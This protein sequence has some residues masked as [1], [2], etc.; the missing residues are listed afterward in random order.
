V[1]KP[2]LETRQALCFAGWFYV[3]NALLLSVAGVQYFSDAPPPADELAAIFRAVIVPGHFLL[4][5]APAGLLVAVLAVTVPGRY[6]RIGAVALFGVLAVLVVADVRVFAL[7]RFHLNSMVW[8]LLTSGVAEEIVPVSPRMLA[9]VA[10]IVVALLLLEVLLARGLWRLLARRRR[11]RG[12]LVAAIVILLVVA[13]QALHAYGDATLR[14]SV[15]REMRYLPWLEGI[16]MKGFL[17][18]LGFPRQEDTRVAASHERTSGLRYPTEP[19]ECTRAADPMNVLI[20][21]IEEWRFDAL[22]PTTTPN[23]WRLAQGGQRFHAHFSAGSSSRYGVFGLMYGLHPSYWDAVLAEHRGTVMIEEAR[24]QGYRFQIRGSASLAHP[25]FDRTVFAALR[26]EVPLRT[27][28]RSAADRDRAITDDFLAFAERKQEPFFGF[29]FYDSPHSADYPADLQVPY[30]PVWKE[31]DYLELDADFD[32]QPYRN[33][34]NNSVFYVDRLIGEVLAA[35]EKAGLDDDTVVI[36]TGDHGEEFNDSGLNYW[37]HNSNFSR[38]QTQVPLVVRWPGRLPHEHHGMT[39]HLDVVPT[40]MGRV[41]GCSTPA[42]AYSNGF[43]L[44]A[45]ARPQFVSVGG[46]SGGTAVIEPQR[47]TLVERYGG[48]RVM[49]LDWREQVGEAPSTDPL[50]SVLESMSVFYAR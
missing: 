45:P 38:Y 47:V 23:V 43:D 26:D 13:G 50:R 22:D 1:M 28:G 40:I 9:R 10:G 25:E 7:Y 4:L 36:V 11:L 18:R 34:H 16:T 31:I 35:L 17:V 44:F 32:P 20:V 21:L 49:D 42:H 39:S 24:R 12:G 14:A 37:G 15:T 30:G 3:T 8:S 27:R 19:L 5:A 29:L 41:L 46:E 6:V 33:R 2:A 48:V